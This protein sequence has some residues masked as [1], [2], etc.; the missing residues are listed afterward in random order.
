MSLPHGEKSF[1]DLYNR[2]ETMSE[3]DGQT[4]RRTDRRTESH[5]IITRLYADVR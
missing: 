2:F 3:S 1:D 4:D 5:I